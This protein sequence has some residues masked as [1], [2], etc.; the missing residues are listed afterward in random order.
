MLAA[1][2]AVD[3]PQSYPLGRLRRTHS[4]HDVETCIGKNGASHTGIGLYRGRKKPR[5]RQCINA[6]PIRL[7]NSISTRSL[8]ARIR[9][10]GRTF[11]PE[12]D[13]SLGQ[14]AQ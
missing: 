7:Q 4:A 3:V 14:T 8:H 2:E 12:G 11:F 1:G 13:T 9:R 5:L 10:R 6:F